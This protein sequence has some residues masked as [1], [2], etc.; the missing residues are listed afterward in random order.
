LTTIITG[1]EGFE[2]IF[3]NERSNEQ[4]FDYLSEDGINFS[5][6]TQ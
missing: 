4:I 6:H 1:C 3:F 5:K 2:Q